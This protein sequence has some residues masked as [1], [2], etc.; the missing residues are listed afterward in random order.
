MEHG[1]LLAEVDRR[2]FEE[3]IAMVGHNYLYGSG[4]KIGTH[5]LDLGGHGRFVHLSIDRFEGAGPASGGLRFRPAHC[6][7]SVGCPQAAHD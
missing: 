5:G 3:A 2:Q 7:F 1:R 4:G 6:S